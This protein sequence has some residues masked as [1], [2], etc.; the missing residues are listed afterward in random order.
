MHKAK[1]SSLGYGAILLLVLWAESCGSG[2]QSGGQSAVPIAEIKS[3]FYEERSSQVRFRG[4]VTVVNPIFGFFVVQDQSAGI[5]VQGAHFVESSLK[6]HKVEVSGTPAT[7][8][9]TGTISDATVRDLGI[10]DLPKPLELLAK[11]LK[12]DSFDGKLVSLTATARNGKVDAAGQLVVPVRVGGFEISVRFMDDHGLDAEQFV[13]A[14]VRVTG[15]ASTGV[16]IDGKLTGLTILAPDARSLEMKQAAPGAASL[17]VLSLGEIKKL[18]GA[19]PAHRVRL[20]GRIENAGDA[21]G[22]RFSDTSGTLGI[23]DFDGFDASTSGPVDLVAFLDQGEGRWTLTGVRPTFEAKVSVQQGKAETITSVARLHALTAAE[24]GQQRPVALD[25][26]LT[27]YEPTWQMAFVRDDTGGVYVSLHGASLEKDRRLPA[28]RAGDRI[29]L[30]GVSGAGDFAPV[31]QAPTFEFVDHVRLPQPASTQTEMIFTGQADSQW[32]ELEGIIQGVGFDGDHPLAKLSYGSHNYKI[33]FPPSVV[34]APDWVDARVRV[35]G[36][37][38]TVF[39][40][41]R[42]VLGIQLFVQ[43]LD[44]VERLPDAVTSGVGKATAVTPI[45]RLLQFHPNEIPGHRV[46]LRGKVLATSAQGPTWIKD[47]SGAVAIREHGEISLTSGDIVD[48]VG[49]AVAG[50]FAVEIHEGVITK[51]SGGAAVEPIDV[52]PEKALFQGVDGQLVRLEGRLLSEYQNG[53]EQ[54]LLLRNGKATFTVRGM[55]NLPTY[56]IGT[57]LNVAGIC[58][59]GVKRF[60]GV[61]VPNSFEIAVDSPRSVAV[62]EKAAWMTQQRAWRVLSITLLLVAAALVWVILLRRRVSGQTRLIEQKLLEVEKLKENAEAANDAKSQFL[63]NMSHEIRTPMNG[64]LGM[65]ELAMQAES[66]EEQKECLSTIRSSGDALLTILN[67]L[68]DLS[69]I[70]AGKFEIEEAPFSLRELVKESGKVFTFRMKEKGLH[71]DATTEEKLPDLLIGDALRL[72]QVLLNLLGN[73]VKFTEQGN[74]ALAATGRRVEDRVILRLAVRDSG[75]GIPAEKQSQVFEAFRQVDS[76]IARNYGGTGLGLSICTKLVSLMG[77]T[78]ELESELGKGTTFTVILSLRVADAP[79]PSSVDS[80]DAPDSFSAP[81][82]ILLAEDNPVN[83][84]VAARLLEKEGHRVTVAGNGKI[85]VAEFQK[86]KFD[87]IIMDVQMPELDGLEATR[88]I[89]RVEQQGEV[90][91]PIIAMTAQTMTGDKDNCI[92]AGMDGFV[93]KP[94]RL[95]ELWAAIKTIQNTVPK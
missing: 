66:R 6:G 49:F 92:A 80:V 35:R 44:Q 78:I 62:V 9:A 68:L 32:V 8:S 70:E 69:K 15:V 30:R 27:Y 93:S 1:K 83:Q 55:G 58:S 39:N 86:A 71:F 72:R 37:A 22:F 53:Q 54:T 73:A 52:T 38:G 76:T 21:D 26:E 25:C 67:D 18:E 41:K 28:L 84:K 29:R 82:N 34:L 91:V 36:A 7:G 19:G 81:L 89:R 95:P 46:H 94:I 90:R 57:V 2:R 60:R 61:L 47:D 14:E 12:A 13:D 74:I 42:Q 10:A 4:V 48:V 31:V 40:G 50:A 23:S 79:V 75:V 45:N 56:E 24:A 11:D 43:G 59:V 63:A 65:T 77:G 51:R 5:R 85:A 20:Q 88:E 87:L 3:S 16:D 64:I 33:I 17:P